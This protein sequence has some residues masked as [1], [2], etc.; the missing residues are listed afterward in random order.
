MLFKTM[1]SLS[2]S[3]TGRI[4]ARGKPFFHGK[5]DRDMTMKTPPKEQEN[6]NQ[7]GQKGR[8]GGESCDRG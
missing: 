5:T 8:N 4:D 6:R 3:S 2:W 7:E 1:L